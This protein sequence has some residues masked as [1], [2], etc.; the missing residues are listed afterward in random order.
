MLNTIEHVWSAVKTRVKHLMQVG[1]HELIAEDPAGILTQTEFR[2][3]FL[4]RCADEALP[5]VTLEMCARSCN[6]VQMHYAAALQQQDM[7]V[8][9]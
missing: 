6:H 8:G 1:F 4:E 7:P 5:H 9:Q 2:L 3:R